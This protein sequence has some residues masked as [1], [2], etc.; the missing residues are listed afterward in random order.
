VLCN[1]PYVN[2]VSM[3]A[4]PAEFRAEP[5]VALAGGI[6][7]MDFVRGLIQGA[8]AV[9]NEGGALV[10]EIGHEIDHFDKAFPGLEATWL[11]AGG[12]DFG[13][14]ALTREALIRHAR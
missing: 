7:G 6:D 11:E 2:A 5:A 10:L 4:L 13:V 8:P 1:P 3:R 12:G 9:M 14:A